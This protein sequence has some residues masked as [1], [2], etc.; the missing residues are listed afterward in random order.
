MLNGVRLFGVLYAMS[1]LWCTLD[2]DIIT[3]RNTEL[4]LM[5]SILFKREST[6]KKLVNGILTSMP[7]L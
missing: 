6:K 1:C 4:Y 3:K 5:R 7:S 2:H